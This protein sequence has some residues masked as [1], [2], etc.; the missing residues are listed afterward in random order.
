M[1]ALLCFRGLKTSFE[2]QPG[3]APGHHPGGYY[4]ALGYS[5]QGLQ[6]LIDT[7]RTSLQPVCVWEPMEMW[8]YHLCARGRTQLQGTLT[9]MPSPSQIDKCWLEGS[10][11]P[12]FLKKGNS[13]RGPSR[14]A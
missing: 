13:G 10:F 11:S 2:L 14:A 4:S 1:P 7:S 3:H 8:G 9:L 12:S 5:P 6:V